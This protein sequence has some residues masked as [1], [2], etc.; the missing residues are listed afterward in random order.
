MELVSVT[1]K[2]VES[3]RFPCMKNRK[4]LKQG[5]V[6]QFFSPK[7]AKKQFDEIKSDGNAEVGAE[8]K[9]KTK[10]MK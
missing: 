10:K 9:K 8:P 7:V 4:A 2:H 3:L 6:L 5:D 1:S